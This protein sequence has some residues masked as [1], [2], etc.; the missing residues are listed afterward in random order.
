MG[1]S[2]GFA[3]KAALQDLGLPLWGPGMDGGDAVA[4]VAGV[5]AAPGTQGSWRLGLQEIQC[6]RRVRQPVL[7]NTLQYSCLEKPF[8]WHRSLAGHSLQGRKEPGHNQ[9]DPESTDVRLFLPV[10]ALPQWELSMKVV[11]LLGLWGS[12]WCPSTVEVTALSES[13]FQASCSWWS[14]GLFG[15]SFSIA[16]PIQAHRG[17]PCLGS[18]SVF[19]HIRHLKGRPGWGLL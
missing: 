16:P 15:Q 9:S 11:Q 12:W 19:P 10:S 7:A 2:L 3:P 14:A 6:S 1:G 17:L 4:W 8:P 13:F 5:L 18:F